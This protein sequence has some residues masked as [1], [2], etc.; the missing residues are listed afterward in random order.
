MKGNITGDY[1]HYNE[2]GRSN[3][4][5]NMVLIIVLCYIIVEVRTFCCENSL[6]VIMGSFSTI[7]VCNGILYE[8]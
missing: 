2:I 1:P 8:L 7:P 4:Y 5:Y 6:A 3:G